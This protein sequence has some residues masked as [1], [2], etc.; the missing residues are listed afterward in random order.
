MFAHLKKWEVLHGGSVDAISTKEVELDVAMALTNLNIR[1]RL[2]LL[3]AIPTRAKFALGAHI[4]TSEVEPKISIPKPIRVTDAAFSPHL[5]DFYAALASL[6]PT[7]R[8]LVIAAPEHDIFTV[9]TLQRSKNLFLGG[10]VLQL[11]VQLLVLGAWRIRWV[12]GASMKANKY[13]GFAEFSQMGEL[14]RSVCECQAGYGP[15]WRYLLECGAVSLWSQKNFFFLREGKCSHLGAAICL[16][17]HFHR[18]PDKVHLVMRRL[19]GIF[20]SYSCNHCCSVS[21]RLPFK[22]QTCIFALYH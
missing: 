15:L 17:S 2:G 9:R 13:I 6:G 16:L 10:A 12:V 14:L 1:A 3:D 11:A 19:R 20:V 4:I 7:L 8:K 22:S 21:G 18:K 5:K